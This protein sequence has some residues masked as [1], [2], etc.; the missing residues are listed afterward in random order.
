MLMCSEPTGQIDI[1]NQE[2]GQN[3]LRLEIHD[4]Y[5]SLIPVLTDLILLVVYLLGSGRPLSP[6][7]LSPCLVYKQEDNS[8]LSCAGTSSSELTIGAWE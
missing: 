6:G 1:I 4:Q 5:R 8:N 3:G 7:G 2:Q